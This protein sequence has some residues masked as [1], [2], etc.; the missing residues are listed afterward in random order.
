MKFQ[1][2]A[3]RRA[4]PAQILKT[5]APPPNTTGLFIVLNMTIG[6][7]SKF[8]PKFIKFCNLNIDNSPPHPQKARRRR[9]FSKTGLLS[10]PWIRPDGRRLFIYYFNATTDFFLSYCFT[11]EDREAENNPAVFYGFLFLSWQSEPISMSRLRLS[12]RHLMTVKLL[13]GKKAKPA[14]SIIVLH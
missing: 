2:G 8:W 7:L 4:R 11:S 6:G 3:R 14:T 10:L 12:G 1:T 5:R 9:R 13:L